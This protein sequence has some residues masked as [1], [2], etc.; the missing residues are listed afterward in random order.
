M[1]K[2]SRKSQVIPGRSWHHYKFPEFGKA[3]SYSLSSYSGRIRIRLR[4]HADNALIYLDDLS[5][6]NGTSN[7]I[8]FIPST[9]ERRKCA[10]NP[11]RF[12]ERKSILCELDCK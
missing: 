6:N 4:G 10:G 8:S 3:A 9:T 11:Q 1:L 12:L 5:I 2:F 7:S